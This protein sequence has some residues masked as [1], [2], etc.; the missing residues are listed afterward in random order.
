MRLMRVL[1][2]KLFMKSGY[3]GPESDS[4]ISNPPYYTSESARVRY[5]FEHQVLRDQFFNLPD[6]TVETILKKDGLLTIFRIATKFNGCDNSYSPEDYHIV[7]MRKDLDINTI[8]I[9][10][11][12]PKYTPLCYRIYIIFSDDYTN[13]GYYTIECGVNNNAFLCGWDGAKHLL[14]NEI[15]TPPMWEGKEKSV[16][17][18]IETLIV[19]DLHAK[20][21]NL[22]YEG[23]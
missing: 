22:C 23:K 14:F 6:K 3:K 9:E 19:I 12:N 11:P 17:I 13:L 16:F 18:S 21:F 4:I 1:G 2:K 5:L 15:K 20:R 7:F 8:C 10:C